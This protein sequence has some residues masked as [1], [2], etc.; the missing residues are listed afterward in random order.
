[1]GLNTAV[2]EAVRERVKN[3]SIK[4]CEVCATVRAK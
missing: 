1:M 3:V 4:Y 2:V